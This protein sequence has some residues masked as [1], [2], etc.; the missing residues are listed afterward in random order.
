M[1]SEFAF[2]NHNTQNCKSRLGGS[3][4]YEEPG[5]YWLLD[6]APEAYFPEDAHKRGGDRGCTF[7]IR[8]TGCDFET[9]G[10]R[11]AR[12]NVPGGWNC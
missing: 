5:T 8:C 3:F 2:R 6:D 7:C 4:L 11:K 12:D 10:C 9:D 1:N